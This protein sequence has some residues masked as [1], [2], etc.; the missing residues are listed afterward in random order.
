MISMDNREAFHLLMKNGISVSSTSCGGNIKT[1]RWEV[2]E[3]KKEEELDISDENYIPDIQ[4][5]EERLRMREAAERA[6]AP[7]VKHETYEFDDDGPN[8]GDPLPT[9]DEVDFSSDEEDDF[10]EE[11]PQRNLTDYK[12]I[13]EYERRTVIST[14]V[15]AMNVDVLDY[16]LEQSANPFQADDAGLRYDLLVQHLLLVFFFERK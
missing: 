10:E 12:L 8:F 9:F 15:A 4:K 3:P 11:E 6:R 16:L 2:I 5:Y 13:A 7:Q 14:A 1:L